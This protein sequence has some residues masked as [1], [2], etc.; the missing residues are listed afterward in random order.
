MRR[1]RKR[2]AGHSAILRSPEYYTSYHL[3]LRG[4]ISHM[5]PPPN[6]FD[7][8]VSKRQWELRMQA[9]RRSLRAL[10]GT[11]EAAL[12]LPDSSASRPRPPPALP[13]PVVPFTPFPL[14]PGWD[15]HAQHPRQF[16]PLYYNLQ[17]GGDPRVVTMGHVWLSRW[18]FSQ[19][20]LQDRGLFRMVMDHH[21][22][23][24]ASFLYPTSQP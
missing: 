21:G 18:L 5:P 2:V 12:S 3:W 8:S 13:V 16:L 14:S 22:F 4:L 1:V 11:H 23:Q 9:W 24:V 7:L 15:P 19:D 6:P 17:L 20:P 10:A